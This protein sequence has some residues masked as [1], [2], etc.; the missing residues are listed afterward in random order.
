[1]APSLF[2]LLD[3]AT[4]AAVEQFAP[5]GLDPGVEALLFAQ[6]DT[7]A[8]AL[9]EVDSMAEICSEEGAVLAGTSDD[10]EEGRM[11][12]AARRLA[13]TA[14]E[15]Q[16]QTILDDVCVPVGK[17]ADLLAGTEEI[18][19]S[20][21][22]TIG[23]FGHAGDGN[24]HPTIVYDGAD[25]DQLRLAERAFAELIEL[26]LE[27][28]GTISGEHG[29]GQLKRAWLTQELGSANELNGR[30]KRALDPHGIL[31]PGKALAG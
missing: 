27:L 16:G 23:T 18:A 10:P 25:P 1:M 2:E 14:L 11:L 8:S 15:H 3:R 29:I 7:G 19:G 24:F 5:Q 12:L 13:Y 30:I 21:G 31:N 20:A 6:S 4:V 28:G 22:L 9:S 17:I 26:A